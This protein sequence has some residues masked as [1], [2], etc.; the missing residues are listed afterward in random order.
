MEPGRNKERDRLDEP[1]RIE[2]DESLRRERATKLA[3][4]ERAS[5]LGRR[6]ISRSIL[7]RRIQISQRALPVAKIVFVALAG[8]FRLVVKSA[9]LARIGKRCA[10]WF[11]LISLQATAN[12]VDQAFRVCIA[13]SVYRRDVPVSGALSNF[14]FYIL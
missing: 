8:G 10:V 2:P 1:F 6:L 4:L 14:H 7:V 12:L 13:R 3:L 9:V 11:A 5:V